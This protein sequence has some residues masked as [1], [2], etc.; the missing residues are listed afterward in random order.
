MKS[1]RRLVSTFMGF[2]EVACKECT[3]DVMGRPMNFSWI[4]DG[5]LTGSAKREGLNG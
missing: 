4:I 3:W 2:V 5:S 1:F